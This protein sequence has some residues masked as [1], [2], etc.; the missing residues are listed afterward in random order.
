ML[1]ILERVVGASTGI[2]GRG[3]ILERLQSN[4]TELFKGKYVGVSYVDTRQKEFLN[5]T[6]GSK[7]VTEYKVEF[8]RL[9]RYARGI[10]ATEYERCV[11][12]EDDLRDELR[13]LIALQK[14]R[15]FAALIEKA[16]IVEEVKCSERQNRKKDKGKNKRDF[17]P[18]SSSGRSVKKAKFDGP[19]RTKVLVAIVKDCPQRQVH[20][21]AAGPNLVQPV[22][23][24]Q[25][26]PRGCGQVRGMD[27]LVKH[28]ARL[29]CVAKRMV[30]KTIEDDEV[31]VIGE[32]NDFLS[33]VISVLRAEKLVR[34]GCEAF[35]A[36]IN[37]SEAEG[38]SVGDVRT[39][40]EFFD[41]FPDELPV[42]PSNH[43]VEFR[44]EL[45]SRI[46]L[47]SIAPYRMTLKE[48][49]ELKAQI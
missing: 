34:K 35:L 7:T 31:V 46:A 8:L 41:V 3:S 47:M 40:K 33:N 38:P 10:V 29:D 12:F 13:V 26:P 48:L 25:Q 2:V 6:Q 1:R 14:E 17:G 37:I 15:Y 18:S 5:L 49:V 39:V 21:Q 19:F 24:G 43:E 28:Q 32:R 20:I 45:L 23:G 36:Y 9:S 44:I 11:H 30:L 27:W 22:R 42:L 4:G 16:K